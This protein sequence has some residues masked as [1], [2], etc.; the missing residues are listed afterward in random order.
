MITFLKEMYNQ[1][2]AEK[3][4]LEGTHRDVQRGGFGGSIA[5]SL[6]APGVVSTLKP[7]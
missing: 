3:K 5:P 4:R 1:T 2:N 6:S 7:L